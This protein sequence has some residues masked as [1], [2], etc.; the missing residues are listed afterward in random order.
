[1]SNVCCSS[2]LPAAAVQQLEFYM[3]DTTLSLLGKLYW[4]FMENKRNDH[5]ML[6]SHRKEREKFVFI[7]IRNAVT[8]LY[9]S[10]FY[11]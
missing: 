7:F 11:S 1:M 2:D 4:E 9:Q 8:N 6:L 3:A 5:L 10:K